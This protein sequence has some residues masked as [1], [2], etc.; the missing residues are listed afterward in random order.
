MKRF[1][2]LLLLTA[3]YATAG[4]QT[5]GGGSS[6]TSLTG[7][8]SSSSAIAAVSAANN[9]GH[10]GLSF[11][12]QYPTGH[13]SG[14]PWVVGQNTTTF[15][16]LPSDGSEDDSSFVLGFNATPASNKII[17]TSGAFGGRRQYMMLEHDYVPIPADLTST[18]DEWHY[19]N[20]DTAA[21]SIRNFMHTWNPTA[22]TSDFWVKG[23]FSVYGNNTQQPVSGGRTLLSS[24][25]VL[26]PKDGVLQA[27]KQ[28]GTT[29]GTV[30]S[31]DTNDRIA[32]GADTDLGQFSLRMGGTQ[33][34]NNASRP[35]ASTTPLAGLEIWSYGN[36]GATS[37]HGLLRL[38]A[39]GGTAATNKTFID[40]S[41]A[42]SVTDMSNTITFFTGSATKV[43]QLTTT[44]ANLT[45]FLT[46]SGGLN[47]GAATDPGSGVISLK[48]VGPAITIS[49][50]S[51]DAVFA[52]TVA[53][54]TASFRISPYQTMNI[55]IVEDNKATANLLNFGRGNGWTI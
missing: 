22:G 12:L 45:G 28:D 27:L 1:I 6:A 36:S 20:E 25:G 13:V 9:S 30:L 33:W 14:A 15:A 39:G 43:L 53:G 21:H 40:I 50:P 18:V 37:N 7:G 29:I 55:L 5:S 3:S 2:A 34:A 52:T 35:A 11:S 41:G 17:N 19:D 38:S 42:S 16:G 31:L 24:N 8:S 44:A 51:S 46:T 54:T 32:A 23:T 10:G 26:L 4:L 47:V 48:G 49:S